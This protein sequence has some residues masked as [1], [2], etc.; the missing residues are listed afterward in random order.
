MVLRTVCQE[1]P[2]KC[3][4]LSRNQR[5]LVHIGKSVKFY[6]DR[7]FPNFRV[8]K[9]HCVNVKVLK[10][11]LAGETKFLFTVPIAVSLKTLRIKKVEP[12]FRTPS[13]SL[14]CHGRT[15]C[16]STSLPSHK[17]YHL[18]V[19]ITPRPLPMD[20]PIKYGGRRPP[21]QK[22]SKEEGLS[23]NYLCCCFLS[24]PSPL[25]RQRTSGDCSSSQDR[26]YT[27]SLFQRTLHHSDF[28][29]S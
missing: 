3:H 24:P 4:F 13:V 25:N 15:H 14:P 18:D 6:G 20:E 11:N 21:E 28:F 29:S 1:S 22:D 16:F 9:R 26:Q 27:H 10:H 8:P 7:V 2:Q 5:T 23:Q 19:L 17:D 12:I